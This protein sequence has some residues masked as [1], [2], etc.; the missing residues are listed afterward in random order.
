MS[1]LFDRLILRAQEAGALRRDVSTDDISALLGSTILGARDASEPD[2][3]RRYVE[4]LL[5]GLRPPA[6]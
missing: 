6:A 3:W 1:H 4:V 2:R 5:A